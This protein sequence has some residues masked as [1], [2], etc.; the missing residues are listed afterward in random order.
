MS[1]DGFSAS[2]T[3]LAEHCQLPFSGAVRRR[4]ARRVKGRGRGV[5][6]HDILTL[7]RTGATIHRSWFEAVAADSGGEIDADTLEKAAASFRSHEQ[8]PERA[9][10]EL[11]LA[12]NSQTREAR[13]LGYNIGRAY[14]EHG[15]VRGVDWC[16]AA[17]LAWIESETETACIVD[18][19]S[20]HWART[21]AHKPQL[22]TLAL[23]FARAMGLT[24]ARVGTLPIGGDEAGKIY[25]EDVADY[26]LDAHEDML[27]ER[28][29]NADTALPNP[30][31]WCTELYCDAIDDCPSAGRI[32]ELALIPAQHLT[33]KLRGPIET[34]EE[35]AARLKLRGAIAAWVK[36]NDADLER[37]ADEHDGIMTPE[38]RWTKVTKRRLDKIEVNEDA[39]RTLVDA[40]GEA[41]A[42]ELTKPK[43]SRS[44]IEAALKACGKGKSINPIMKRLEDL[45]AAKYKTIETY[46]FEET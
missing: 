27:H 10:S 21:D 28:L 40:V 42:M 23:F 38:G 41:A 12:Y 7:V 30:G 35:A 1:F 13:I 33:V 4:D 39:W 37:W 24:R 44:A 22:L 16:G 26:E 8:I 32:A 25:F 9:L 6:L 19:K 36:Q 29:A 34:V 14:T 15:A 11:A 18:A 43:T 31:W 45:D 20:G 46:D 2:A 3:A 5:A 17:D